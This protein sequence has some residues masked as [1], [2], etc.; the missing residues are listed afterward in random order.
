MSQS[1]EAPTERVPRSLAELDAMVDDEVIG[2]IA[3]QGQHLGS[4]SFNFWMNE[5][6]RRRQRAD[7]ESQ[8]KLT[9]TMTRLT[10][11]VTI[12]TGLVL[13]ATVTQIVILIVSD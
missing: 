12:M 9:R 13:A 5:L 11:A 8:A 1:E 3:R 10:W 6:E 7:R 4:T 2:Q